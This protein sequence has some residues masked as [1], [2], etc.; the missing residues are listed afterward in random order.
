VRKITYLL[1]DLLTFATFVHA[2]FHDTEMH[3]AD[4][5][6]NIV[7]CGVEAWLIVIGIDSINC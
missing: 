4:V 7:D 5:L 6:S 1:S 3:S 2:T